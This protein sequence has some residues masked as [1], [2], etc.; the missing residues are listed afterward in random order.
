MQTG[1][2]AS[3]ARRV[4]TVMALE[5]RSARSHLL[6]AELAQ[7]RQQTGA[8]LAALRRA[9][10]VQPSTA[11][12]MRLLLQLQGSDLAGAVQVAESWLRRQPGDR[13]IRRALAELHASRAQ[14]PAARGHFDQLLAQT[15]NDAP[16]LNNLALIWLRLN[17]PP[18]ARAHAERALKAAPGSPLVLDTLAWVLHHQGDQEHALGLLRDARLRAPDHAEIRYHLAAVLAKMG[19]AGEARAELRA[20]LDRPLGLE[21]VKD[22][23]A[24]L[25]T[26]K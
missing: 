2:L 22:A 10:E 4:D 19:R 18:K 3:A 25:A 6:V 17:D 23:Q 5:P 20:A 12:T 21:S 9:H 26:L 24:L 15:P 11:T 1:D 14:W 7:A 16:T 8:A 13:D